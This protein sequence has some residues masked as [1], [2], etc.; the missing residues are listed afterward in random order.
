[1]KGSFFSETYILSTPRDYFRVFHWTYISSQWSTVFP[2]RENTTCFKMLKNFR[3]SYLLIRNLSSVLWRNTGIGTPHAL[4]RE[5]HQYGRLAIISTMAFWADPGMNFTFFNNSCNWFTNQV[6]WKNFL[7][8]L[9]FVLIQSF[10]F[11][12]YIHSHAPP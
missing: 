1:M 4:C 11:T 5:M 2:F 12:C 7:E 9:L 10:I 3:S 6:Q 8:L